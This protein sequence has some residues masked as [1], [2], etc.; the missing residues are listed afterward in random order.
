MDFEAM[1]E[2]ANHALQPYIE[3]DLTQTKIVLLLFEPQS[4]LTVMRNC[5]KLQEVDDS[6]HKL[7][8]W[9]F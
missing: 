9:S 2:F 3:W 8:N 1:L 5:V 7:N 6:T 4:V